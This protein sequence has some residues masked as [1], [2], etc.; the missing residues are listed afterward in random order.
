MVNLVYHISKCIE[1]T[2]DSIS[3]KT[4]HLLIVC[5]KIIFDLKDLQRFMSYKFT[6]Y[7]KCID[8]YLNYFF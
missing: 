8:I 3:N 1:F 5:I 4:C 6:I 2:F 7:V